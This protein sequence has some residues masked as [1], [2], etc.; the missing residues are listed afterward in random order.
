MQVEG[1]C[2]CGKIRYRAEVFPASG[3]LHY[4]DCQTSSGSALRTVMASN[5]DSFRLL[6]GTTGYLKTAESSRRRA[7]L[8]S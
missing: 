6:S 1:G 7:N 8:S 3:D 5:A 4:P 2:R